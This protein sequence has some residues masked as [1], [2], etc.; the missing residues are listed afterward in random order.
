MPKGE[1]RNATA[2][3][4]FDALDAA[5]LVKLPAVSVGT[6]KVRFGFRA[7]ARRVARSVPVD[8]AAGADGEIAEQ[9]EGRELC[10]VGEGA[11]RRFAAASCFEPFPVVGGMGVRHVAW[12]LG[13]DPFPVRGEQQRPTASFRNKQSSLLANYQ[14]AVRRQPPSPC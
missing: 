14:T 4:G 1:W 7:A 11:A 5:L 8:G 10:A 2:F 6:A 3:S 9:C 13:F 12:P